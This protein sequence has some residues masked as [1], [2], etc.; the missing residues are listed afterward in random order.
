M[1]WLQVT[2]ACI[3]RDKDCGFNKNNSFP[4]TRVSACRSAIHPNHPLPTCCLWALL[5]FGFSHYLNTYSSI[6]NC[7][8]WYSF[9]STSLP[10]SLLPSPGGDFF[11]HLCHPLFLNVMGGRAFSYQVSLLWTQLPVL[12]FNLTVRTDSGDWTISLLCWY[13]LR[14]LGDLLS[15]SHLCS[16]AYH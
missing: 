13:W 12:Y 15:S 5:S 1:A 6:T 14:Q 11:F 7:F 2:T 3:N 4:Q 9:F 8:Q 16:T 10:S